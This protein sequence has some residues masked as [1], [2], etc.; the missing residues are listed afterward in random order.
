MSLQ[1]LSAAV[2]FAA[3][4]SATVFSANAQTCEE[5]QFS[6]KTGQVY[7]D[8]ENFMIQENF[9]E[10]QKKVAQLKAMELNCYER[11]VAV[12]LSAALNVQAGDYA[13]GARD[14]EQVINMGLVT[15]KDATETYYQIAQLYLQLEDN[16]KAVQFLEKWLANGAQPNKSQFMQ[17]AVLYNQLGNNT[18]ALKYLEQMLA[19]EANPDKQA[20]DFAVYLYNELGQKAK[21]ADFLA[22]KVIPRFASEKRYW[23]VMGGLYFEDEK[24]ADAFEV[25]KAM[26]LAGMLT[27]ESEIMRVVN[28]YNTFN[29]PY[30]SAKI[31]EKEMNAGRIK[32]SA[33]KLETL[34][35]LYQVAREYD[36]A[37]PV[38]QEYAQATNSGRAYERLGRSFF[39]LKKY[40]DAEK[41]LRT[42][43]DKG[44]MREPGFAW[45][46]IGQMYH[47]A[48]NREAARRAFGNASKLGDRGG[49]GWL[50]FMDS[51]DATAEALRTFDT[52]VKL[53]EEK[54]IQKA[55]DQTKVL[56]GTPSENCVGVE[57]RIAALE[58]ELGLREPEGEVGEDGTPVETDEASLQSDDA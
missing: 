42:A 30:E 11:G 58:I 2:A 26:Y 49:N 8:A 27:T 5:T 54:N 3:V 53:D 52:R 12:R 19:I 13:A 14:L 33:E 7:L 37:I 17:L 36:R 22:N 20:I 41:A 25:T 31:L 1:K 56:G 39:E 34:A 28:F 55:C 50:S 32:K 44:N 48:G 29:A 18:S 15:G 23:E 16:N 4:M 35:N 38:I 9:A 45:I 21:L 57:D 43:L 10:A 47:E 46:L 51:E 6:S 24:D 40:D